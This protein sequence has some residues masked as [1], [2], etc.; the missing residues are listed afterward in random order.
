MIAVPV[1]VNGKVRARLEVESDISEEEILQLAICDKNI[2][3]HTDGKAIKSQRYVKG[4]I[5]SIAVG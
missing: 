4:R 1:Q 2:R 5:V 3:K